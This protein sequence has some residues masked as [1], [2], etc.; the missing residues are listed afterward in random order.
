M[1]RSATARGGPVLAGAGNRNRTL[2]PRPNRAR[3]GAPRLARPRAVN[4]RQSLST[5]AA[6]ALAALV[7]GPGVQRIV[8]RYP[9]NRT[10]MMGPGPAWVKRN[11]IRCTIADTRKPPRWAGAVAY[12]R[13]AP[14]W[15]GRARGRTWGKSLVGLLALVV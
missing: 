6:L 3:P 11:A 5:A 15:A 7:T 14:G 2:F 9:V 13:G 12:L 10:R 8:Q 4:V 1:G